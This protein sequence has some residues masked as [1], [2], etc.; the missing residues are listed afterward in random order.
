MRRW[1]V[2]F[3]IKALVNSRR[4]RERKHGRRGIIRMSIVHRVD[5]FLALRE[6]FVLDEMSGLITHARTLDIY[7]RRPELSMGPIVERFGPLR[8]RHARWAQWCL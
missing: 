8:R 4:E 5:F 2:F 1:K 3:M 7:G 6:T